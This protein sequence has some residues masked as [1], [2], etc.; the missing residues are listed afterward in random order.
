MMKVAIYPGTF[1]PFTQGHL[2]CVERAA[3][4][5]DQV[6]VAVA[7][8]AHKLPLIAYPERCRLATQVCAS[9]PTVR[10]VPMNGL[11]VDLAQALGAGFV[12]RGLR[13]CADFENELQQVDLNQQ[14]APDIETVLIATEPHL[15]A[16]SASRVREIARLGKNVT[17]WVP[18]P[19][20]EYLAESSIYGPFDY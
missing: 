1:D 3:K 19:V 2:R 9:I 16:I 17:Q 18:Q 8:G 20:A 14:M 4:L 5:F 7:Q 13:N 10:V 12:V 11:L 6:V 15:R